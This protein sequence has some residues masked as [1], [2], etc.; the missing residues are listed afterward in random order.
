M[1]WIVSGVIEVLPPSV[2]F[3]M[4]KQQSA[5]NPISVVRDLANLMCHILTWL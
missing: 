2:R 3:L 4:L 5:I 1:Y